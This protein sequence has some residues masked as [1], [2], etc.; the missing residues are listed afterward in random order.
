MCYIPGLERNAF[1]GKL[2]GS[3]F[4]KQQALN[5]YCDN[6]LKGQPPHPL[7]PREFKVQAKDDL[8]KAEV[9]KGIQRCGKQKAS[10]VLD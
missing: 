9:G 4:A 10:I 7:Q 8:T 2:R 1:G 3:A 5:K 6:V